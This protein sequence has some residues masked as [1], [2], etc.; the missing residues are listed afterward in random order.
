MI[1]YDYIYEEDYATLT[2]IMKKDMAILGV[3][4]EDIFIKQMLIWEFVV[5]QG[6]SKLYE[7]CSFAWTNA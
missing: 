2:D 7:D 6:G 1:S 5:S 4:I 3:S